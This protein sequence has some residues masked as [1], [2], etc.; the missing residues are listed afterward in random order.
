[1]SGVVAT[2]AHGTITQSAS[3]ALVGQA[4]TSGQGIF[5]QQHG[6]VI[7]SEQG[8]LAPVLSFPIS[9]QEITSAHGF[10][11]LGTSGD[12]VTV[13]IS[14]EEAEFSQNSVIQGPTL[15]VGSGFT[16]AAGSVTPSRD[17]PLTGSASTVSAGSVVVN[18]QADDTYIASASGSY[19]LSVSL[20]ITG[21]AITSA[22]GSLSTDHK[23]AQLITGLVHVSVRDGTIAPVTSKAL[24]GQSITSAQQNLGAPGFAAL[25]GSEATVSPGF[26]GR[27]YAITGQE[28]TSATGTI[29]GLPGIVALVGESISVGQGTITPSGTQWDPKADPT[30]A[31]TRAPDNA[32]VWTRKPGVTTTWNRKT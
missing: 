28:I 14:G 4:I 3:V 32:A 30:T 13:H 22:S 1:M 16:S 8:S 20:P 15:L 19:S 27:A 31:W 12:D 25:T 6:Q 11:S 9:G 24:T 21:S 5:E 10:V 7:Y 26:L 2:F 29:V 17:V 18:Q 23:E